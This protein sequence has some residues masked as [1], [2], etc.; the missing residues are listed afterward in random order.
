[1]DDFFSHLVKLSRVDLLKNVWDL[2]RF[3]HHSASAD[4]DSDGTQTL[5][6]MGLPMLS[7]A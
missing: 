2:H 7:A 3:G 4:S 5:T 6:R 1:M